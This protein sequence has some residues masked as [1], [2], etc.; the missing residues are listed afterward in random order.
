VEECEAVERVRLCLGL[1]T[2]GT[3]GAV[4][5]I[6][7]FSAGAGKPDGHRTTK[8]YHGIS[9]TGYYD[10]GHVDYDREQVN[11]NGKTD[12]CNSFKYLSQVHNTAITT[13]LSM[14]TDTHNAYIIVTV[15][16]IT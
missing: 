13:M 8:P 1:K 15:S 5:A 6:V 12:T 7:F 4:T 10:R 11:T 14:D 2:I 3:V 16:Q 9:G